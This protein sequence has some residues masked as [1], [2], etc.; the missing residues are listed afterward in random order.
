MPFH[1]VSLTAEFMRRA[2]VPVTLLP[3]ERVN[4]YTDWKGEA[5]KGVLPLLKKLL[6]SPPSI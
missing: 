3:I 2:H 4:H 5:L 6:P 1:A